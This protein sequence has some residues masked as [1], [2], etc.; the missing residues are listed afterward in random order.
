MPT[1]SQGVSFGG[2]SGLTNVKWKDSRPDPLGG[3]VDSSTL[4][5]TN[6]SDRT[7]I[8]GLG[9]GWITSTVTATGTGSAPSVGGTYDGYDC[10]EVETENAA[11]ELAKWTATFTKKS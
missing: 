5:L 3:R 9:D 7:Y 8:A 10:V 2:L 4:D 11:G 6:G 1:S